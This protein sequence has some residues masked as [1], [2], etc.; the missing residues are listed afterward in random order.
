MGL[1]FKFD[2]QLVDYYKQLDELRD[3]VNHSVNKTRDVIINR[4]YHQVVV[5]ISNV[6]Y[7]PEAIE[8]FEKFSIFVKNY[9]ENI[10]EIFD[11]L[12]G[13]LEIC[14]EELD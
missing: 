7:V 2:D 4:I 8:Y 3:I 14:W 9:G 12:R 10:T 6:W 11:D 5:P 1:F 13:T